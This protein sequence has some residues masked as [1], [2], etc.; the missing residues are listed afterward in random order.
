M[1]PQDCYWPIPGLVVAGRWPG[2]RELDWLEAVGVS[3]LI[4]LTERPYEDERFHV[5]DMPIPEFMAPEIDQIEDLCRLVDA[6]E[7][8]GG[9]LYIHCYA[10]CGRTGT[11]AACL[12]VR[13]EGLSARKA[14]DHIRSLRDCSIESDEQEDGVAAWEEY[15]REAG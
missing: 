15:L 6:A 4:N 1:N 11:M 9:V 3:A 5:I 14:I 13:R 8:R 2:P 7:E 12:L 10:G